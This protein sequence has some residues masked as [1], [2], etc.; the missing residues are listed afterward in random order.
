M[1][2]VTAA[3]AKV[4]LYSLICSVNENSSPIAI[5]SSKGKGAVLIGEDEWAAIEGTLHL[6]EVPG[7]AE[8]LVECKNEPVSECIEEV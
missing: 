2:A 6:S 1:R 3:V 7:M 5:A 4:N 8:S